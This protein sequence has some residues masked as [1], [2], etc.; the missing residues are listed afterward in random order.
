MSCSKLFQGIWLNVYDSG[1]QELHGR[2]R[3]M[4][5]RS[6]I[7]VK[8]PTWVAVDSEVCQKSVMLALSF[9]RACAIT[10]GAILPR[11]CIL[12]SLGYVGI[13]FLIITIQLEEL[14]LNAV[15]L[16]VV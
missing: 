14:I 3:L 4:S 13:H 10:I 5:A 1:A 6:K 15:A 11:A 16:E 2:S 7:V 9:W 12:I 8:T